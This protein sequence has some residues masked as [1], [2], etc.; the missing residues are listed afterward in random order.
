MTPYPSL[1]LL[2]TPLMIL[3][4]SYNPMRDTEGKTPKILPH[5]PLDIIIDSNQIFGHIAKT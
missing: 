5:T 4:I 2:D 3:R 1:L